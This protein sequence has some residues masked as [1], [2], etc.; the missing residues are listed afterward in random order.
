MH[1]I[2]FIS[3]KHRMDIKNNNKITKI[4]IKENKCFLHREMLGWLGLGESSLLVCKRL[5]IL[6]LY[7]GK[8]LGTSV[9]RSLTCLNRIKLVNEQSVFSVGNF[10]YLCRYL[11]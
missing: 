7:I 2:L 9:L 1:I 8:F 4:K 11:I 3:R 5:K 6:E 10:I